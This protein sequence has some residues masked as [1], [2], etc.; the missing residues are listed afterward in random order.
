MRRHWSV[1][2]ISFALRK[3]SSRRHQ[4][5]SRMKL[6]RT[7]RKP[8]LPRLQRA[9]QVGRN[10][11]SAT[12]VDSEVSGSSNVQS[13]MLMVNPA[14]MKEFASKPSEARAVTSLGMMSLE[15][16]ALSADHESGNWYIDNGASRHITRN[17]ENFVTY[18]KFE[19]PH[20]VTVGN[21]QVLAAV[22]QGTLK[23]VAKVVYEST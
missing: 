8:W 6:K 13:G 22:G 18:E 3:G 10:P 9:T 16:D 12:I 14:T 2:L 5:R 11:R 20:G 1:L 17:S 23:I 19:L 4:P 21:G 7:T 15:Q